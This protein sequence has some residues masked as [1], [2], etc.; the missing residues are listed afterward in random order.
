MSFL[1]HSNTFSLVVVVVA[2]C[3]IIL[4][5][6]ASIVFPS[7]LKIFDAF[8]PS[9]CDCGRAEKSTKKKKKKCYKI[10]AC[11]HILHMNEK[12]KG[13]VYKYS[14]LAFETQSCVYLQNKK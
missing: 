14:F 6:A 2:A 8:T 9:N 12:G 13:G 5:E 10:G 7:V 1:T 11:L 4:S 3:A